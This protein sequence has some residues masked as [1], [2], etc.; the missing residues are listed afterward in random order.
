MARLFVFRLLL[1][2]RCAAAACDQQ[3]LAQRLRQSTSAAA[4]E[5]ACY[6]GARV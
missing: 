4:Y 6:A 2:R 5:K 3:L 1:C